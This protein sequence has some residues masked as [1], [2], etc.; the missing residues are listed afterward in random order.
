MDKKSDLTFL[1]T[2]TAGDP[3]KMKK[4]ISMFLSGAAP[5][6]DSIKAN[7]AAADWPALRTA[8]H[9]LKSQ[10]KYMG[11][12]EAEEL[13]FQVEHQAGSQTSLDQIPAAVEKLEAVTLQ[14]CDELK[15]ELEV[16]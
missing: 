13:A 14:A 12:R 3:V 16:L 11:I 1:R 8:A 4:Y 9:S 5:G 2:F 10:V 6:L 15:A 7:L